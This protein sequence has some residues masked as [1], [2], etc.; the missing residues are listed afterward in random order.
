ME[1]KQRKT[2]DTTCRELAL[3]A[4]RELLVAAEARPQQPNVSRALILA[5]YAIAMRP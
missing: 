4:C 3:R 2:K 1:R 5:R